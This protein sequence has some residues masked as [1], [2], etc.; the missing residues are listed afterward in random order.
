MTPPHPPLSKRD[1]DE[2]ER[3]ARKYGHAA[4]AIAA[5]SAPA[6]TKRG[7]P[8]FWSSPGVKLLIDI[9][10]E[11]ARDPEFSRDRDLVTALK[12]LASALRDA[13]HGLPS[14][15]VHKHPDMPNVA[16]RIGSQSDEIIKLQIKRTKSPGIVSSAS[17]KKS[18]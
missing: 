18:T 2:I 12:D 1:R 8:P 5:V 15:M 6:R 9:A 3:F 10:E 4:V 11:I 17:V 7:R 16:D 14:I 13:E